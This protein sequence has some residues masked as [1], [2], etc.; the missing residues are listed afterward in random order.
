MKHVSDKHKQSAQ[1][2]KA[3]K[4]FIVLANFQFSSE[5]YLFV[6]GFFSSQSLLLLSVM[7]TKYMLHIVL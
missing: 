6:E 3:V 4:S 7:V 5:S 2:F 1:M